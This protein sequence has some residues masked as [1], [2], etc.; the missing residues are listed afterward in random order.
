MMIMRN[1]ATRRSRK[2]RLTSWA[3]FLNAFGNFASRLVW[4]TIGVIVLA[5]IGRYLLV[6]SQRSEVSQTKPDVSIQAPIAWHEVDTEIAAALRA[7]HTTAESYAKKR[8]ATWTKGLE[9]RIDEDFLTWYFSYWQQQWLGLKTM[10]YWLADH[11][12][13]EN[14]IGEQPSMAEGITEEIQE[15]FAKRVLRPQIAQLQLERIADET[16]AVY[17]AEIQQHLATIPKKYRIPQT[18]WDRYLQDIA[19]L[20][21]TAEGNREVSLSLKTIAATG[22][23]GGTVAAVNVARLLQP[24]MARIGSKMTTRAAAHGAGQAAAKIASK[25]GAKVG[26]RVGGKFLGVIVGAGVMVWDVWDHHRTTQIEKPILRQNLKD[27][28]Q[29]L[30]YSL[31]YESETGLM[32]MLTSL[33][34]DM[35]ASLQRSSGKRKEPGSA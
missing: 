23:A 6:T 29:E 30:E 24:M 4:T 20:T 5:A 31:L 28:L 35:V 32:A 7:S 9:K 22:I 3:S 10:G 27:Y 11:A 14:V 1:Q 17:V 16:V 18:D 13:V 26:A 33:E 34:A 2:N 12:I 8:L 21:S 15:A 25:T 19:V